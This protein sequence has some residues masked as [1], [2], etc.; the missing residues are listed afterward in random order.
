MRCLDWIKRDNAL[1][2]DM[3]GTPVSPGDILKCSDPSSPWEYLVCYEPSYDLI[4][5]RDLNANN[6]GWIFDGVVEDYINIGH[7][8]K[9]PEVLCSDDI[10]FYFGGNLE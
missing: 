5:V 8:S 6:V 4:E 10:E 1:L 7:Y 9:N 3:N 2:V